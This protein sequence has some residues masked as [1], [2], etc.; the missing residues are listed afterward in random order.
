MLTPIATE[1][2]EQDIA[3]IDT[4]RLVVIDGRVHLL[5]IRYRMLQNPELARAMGFSD[6][7]QSYEFV[8]NRSEIT[9]QIGNAVPVNMAAALVTAV[10]VPDTDQDGAEDMLPAA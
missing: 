10:L 1:I 4:R 9:K 6:D 7:E 3:E 2:T 5:D 8:G